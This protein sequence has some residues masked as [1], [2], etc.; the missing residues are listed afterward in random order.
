VGRASNDGPGGH[1]TTVYITLGGQLATAVLLSAAVL[2]LAGSRLAYSVAAGACIGI[3]PGAYLAV[4]MLRSARG[5]SPEQMLRTVYVGS[6]M[7]IAMSAAMFVIAIIALDV[8]FGALLGGYVAVI[9][10]Y[11]FVLLL[12]VPGGAVSRNENRE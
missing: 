4:R 2:L 7:K 12:P 10:V 1:K 6:A 11:W 8:S 3:V 9:A 5:A